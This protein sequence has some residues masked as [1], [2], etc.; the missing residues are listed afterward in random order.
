MSDKLFATITTIVSILVIVISILLISK[1]RDK[2]TQSIHYISK[3]GEAISVSIASPHKQIFHHHTNS[4]KYSKKT[5][6]KIHHKRKKIVRHHKTIRKRVVKKHKIIKHTTHKKII[7]KHK[8]SK[9][10]KKPKKH[11]ETN[12]LF[13]SIKMTNSNNKSLKSKQKGEGNGVLNRYLASIEKRLR[14]WPAQ[15]NFA[16]EEIDVRLK[17]YPNGQFDYKI[18]RYSDNQ[19]FNDALISY[20][21]QLKRY[22]FDP[23]R[24]NRAYEIE[25][26][27]VAH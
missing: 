1:L 7:Q 19:A 12:K 21:E 4:K 13:S 11:I 27:F 26:K 8:E 25:V 20:L 17:I 23:H 6:K 9:N 18:M 2:N 22:G 14:G 16:G 3:R 10:I 24:G 15:S 5:H